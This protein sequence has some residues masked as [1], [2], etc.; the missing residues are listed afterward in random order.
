MKTYLSIFLS[1]L[2]CSCSV[3][4]NKENLKK[5]YRLLNT[6]P[7]SAMILLEQTDRSSFS[8]KEQAQYALYYSIAQD[9][10][11]LD[12]D[13]DTLL[14]VAY[15]Y[16]KDKPEDSLYAKSN[17][18]MGLYYQQVDSS[19][20]ATD[21]FYNAIHASEKQQDLYTQYL[22]SN[23]LSWEL[24]YVDPEEGLRY[25]KAAYRFYSQ[26]EDV[27]IN[28]K[29]Y[30]LLRVEDCYRY[31]GKTDSAFFYL[32]EAVRLSEDTKDMNLLSNTYQSL[33]IVYSS[34]E[35]PD[36]ALYYAKL[37]RDVSVGQESS[38]Y[39]NLAKFYLNV[40]SVNQAEKVLKEILLRP[41]ND[42]TKYSV[43]NKLLTLSLGNKDYEHVQTYSDSTQ[44]YLKKIYYSSECDNQNYRKDNVDLNDRNEN[45]TSNLENTRYKSFVFIVLLIC[46]ICFICCYFW[47]YRR[48]LRRKQII[49]KQK[50]DMLLEQEK[51]RYEMAEMQFQNQRE[52]MEMKHNMN[53][54]KQRIL[55]ESTEKQLSVMKNYVVSKMNF[56]QE[57]KILKS[58]RK[59]HDLDNDDWLEI[60]LFLNDSAMGFMSSFREE[61]P[62]LKKSDYKLCML[63]KLGLSNQ[64]LARFYGISL[65]SIKHKLFMLKPKLDIDESSFSARE[66]IKM[67]LK[68]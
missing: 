47:G 2:L 18:Y 32:R 5:A 62:N 31:A 67:W 36:S 57:L 48:L 43:Y 1:L 10:S 21:C 53:L 46:I 65:E 26:L 38:K 30:L 40:D 51:L 19:K 9:K 39:Y 16:Y 11:G 22:A 34:V 29:I 59:I 27:N 45:L 42:N 8:K 55:L 63:L 20:R 49:E 3:G 13:K 61:F 24:Q 15:D 28:N 54:E 7:D 4:G 35:M 37:S 41:S 33:S 68:E 6:N 25:A 50:A 58:E 14:R 56:E 44:F 12:V 60:E 66:Y 17:Y 64:E 23:R 52:I